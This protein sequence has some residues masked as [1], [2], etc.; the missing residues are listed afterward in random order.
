V[1]P[2]AHGN[3]ARCPKSK[4]VKAAGRREVDERGEAV[5]RSEDQGDDD[6]DDDERTEADRDVPIH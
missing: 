4:R 6:D 2:Q 3:K 1:A 5:P